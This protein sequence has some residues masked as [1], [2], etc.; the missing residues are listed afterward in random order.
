MTEVK[1]E[2]VLN[3]QQ[4]KSIVRKA[5]AEK[6][7]LKREGKNSFDKYSYFSEAQYK[8][9]FTKFFS[10]AGIDFT[11]DEELIEEI[12]GTEKMP[13]GRRIKLKI[14]L[15]N[16]DKPQETE[17]VYSSGEGMDKGDKALYKAKTGALKYYL[18]DNFMVATGDDPE[19]ETPDAEGKP[20]AEPLAT[21]KQIEMI[22]GKYT[23]EQIQAM[24]GRM[25]HK[26]I[27][28]ITIKEASR[29]INGRNT[30]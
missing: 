3:L 13:F 22:V 23:E 29:M 30:Q 25:N 16:I 5:L 7:I 15:T 28:E 12:A 4:R 2:K 9:L 18:A 24:L 10:D 1:E 26:S 14:T 21:Q 8:E 19:T 20:K 27:N 17:T 6:G 11:A